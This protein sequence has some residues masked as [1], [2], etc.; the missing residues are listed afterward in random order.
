MVI[1]TQVRLNNRIRVPEIR[2]VDDDGAQLG[3]M[4]TSQALGIAQRKGLDLVEVASQARPPVCRIVDYGK[5]RFEQEKRDK[6]QRKHQSATRVK[7]V[8][9]HPSISD[10][11][12]GTKLRH[13]REFIEDGHRVKVNLFFR[14]RENAHHEFGF[15]LMQRLI[16]DIQDLA[17][18][19]QPP[20]LMGRNLGVMLCPKPNRPG[21]KPERPATSA[22]SQP[23]PPAPPAPAPA[24]ATALPSLLAPQN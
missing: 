2:V 20:R 7:E 22:A 14:G 16:A 17:V 15:Q 23:R 21:G 24:P 13:M 8:Q 18:I 19:E 9:L 6:Q 11:D 4:P 5:F 10:N 12:Y 1:Y 3:I